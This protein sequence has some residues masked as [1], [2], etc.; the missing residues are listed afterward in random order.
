M[1]STRFTVPPLPLQSAKTQSKTFATREYSWCSPP[2]A[3]LTRIVPG[4]GNTG[5]YGYNNCAASKA[6]TTA[7]RGQGFLALLRECPV[8]VDSRHWVCLSDQGSNTA[9]SNLG[10]WWFIRGK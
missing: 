5:T 10:Y 9:V 2:S 1:L 6:T 3:A 7:L 4:S 8:R